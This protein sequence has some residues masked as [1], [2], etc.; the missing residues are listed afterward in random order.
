M[1]CVTPDWDFVAQLKTETPVE[2][3]RRI[4]AWH[5]MMAE[6][7]SLGVGRGETV[8]A[9][10]WS[11]Q[12]RA[13]FFGA[14]YRLVPDVTTDLLTEGFDVLTIEALR[15]R[16]ELPDPSEDG[17]WREGDTL[18]RLDKIND[19]ILWFVLR[20]QERHNLRD[21]WITEA[22]FATARL[23]WAGDAYGFSTPN[24]MPLILGDGDLWNGL[25]TD[26]DGYWFAQ[27]RESPLRLVWVGEHKHV[28]VPVYLHD[29]GNPWCPVVD[30]A[31]DVVDWADDDIQE[32][33]TFDP[34]TEDVQTVAD[35]I[36][37]DVIRPRLVRR[38]NIIKTEDTERNGAIEPAPFRTVQAFE[39]LVRY[40]VLGESKNAIA[41]G[42]RKDRSYVTTEVNRVS[43]MIGLTLRS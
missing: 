34:R 43:A 26:K 13:V 32:I 30:D 21:S 38:L 17:S 20:W 3:Y 14:L 42:V 18:Q 33:G 10:F 8:N 24:P 23:Q 19:D 37:V 31:G 41:K 22:A 15:L 16:R 9:R 1:E 25:H 29:V 28:R 35:R 2:A 40:Q 4:L 5:T 12:V 27:R 6:L 7:K 36:F 39:W 11:R